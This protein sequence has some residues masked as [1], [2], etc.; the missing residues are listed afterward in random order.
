MTPPP[1]NKSNSEFGLVVHDFS[2]LCTS[3]SV[4][5]RKAFITLFRSQTLP[6]VFDTN[7]S[8]R[9]R[10]I[11]PQHETIC[12]NLQPLYVSPLTVGLL[13]NI[14][15]AAPMLESTIE[16]EKNK[17][18]SKE[19]QV[20]ESLARKTT[21]NYRSFFCRGSED[22]PVHPTTP[23]NKE[24]N[25]RIRTSIDS[26]LKQLKSKILFPH[27]TTKSVASNTANSIRAAS[28]EF[29][30]KEEITGQDMETLYAREGFWPEGECEMR[31]K[32][33]PSGV[34][35]RTYYAAGGSTYRASRYL[36][37]PFN[38]LSDQ[39]EPTERYSRVD[40]FRMRTN[41]EDDYFFIYDLTSFTSAFH[42]QRH[43]LSWLSLY[44]RGTTVRIYDP[45]SGIIRKDLGDMISEYNEVCNIFPTY[46]LGV[47]DF[48]ASDVVLFHGVAGFLGVF[49]N[50]V[51]CTLCHG[52]VMSQHC[53][54]TNNLGVAGDDAVIATQNH[55]DLLPTVHS[56]GT[57]A[58]DKVYTS[59]ET[60]VY[61]KRRFLQVQC[62]GLVFD[63]VIWPSF[64]WCDL[65]DKRWTHLRST[66]FEKQQHAV[67][68]SIFSFIRKSLHLV[69]DGERE[70]VFLRL[71][72]F[73]LTYLY[74]HFSLPFEGNLPQCGGKISLGVVPILDKDWFRQDP[75][76]RLINAYFT[77]TCILPHRGLIMSND[78]IWGEGTVFCGNSTKF[79][80]YA[81]RVGWMSK[82]PKT[83]LMIGYPAIQRLKQEFYSVEL[84][85]P[86]IYEYRIELDLEDHLTALNRDTGLAF[87]T[88]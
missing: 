33:Y 51:T 38:L 7:L 63:F 59:L 10:S 48:V 14:V 66:T 39:F 26:W 2:I 73:T 52:Y 17:S 85:E 21:I 65:K 40:R 32:W 60:A 37:D 83:E 36:R 27:M 88:W 71:A 41:S 76:D 80:N 4:E 29:C 42:E 31:Q 20:M 6:T 64:S 22:E 25:L 77:G 55:T 5:Q 74:R 54:S 69:T 8:E 13:I 9:L 68:S 62:T 34:T 86:Q 84:L 81:C 16:D 44:A 72:T 11:L 75:L 56:L 49:G 78:I 15:L 57:F 67:S 30:D 35:P 70:I 23:I 87:N 79:R 24:M 47:G 53:E 45:H 12:R 28:L 1:F 58:E 82:S 19:M 61:L 18:I 46:S 43:F 50:L 3:L